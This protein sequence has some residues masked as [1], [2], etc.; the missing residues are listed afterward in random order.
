VLHEVAASDLDMT[1][2]VNPFRKLLSHVRFFYGEVEHI[3]LTLKQ[4]TV[5]HG[6]KRHSHEFR[7]DYL[8]LAFGSTTNVFGLRSEQS[9]IKMSAGKGR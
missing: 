6:P 5:T 4:V 7:Y 3:D 1:H 8:V 2:I 9:V